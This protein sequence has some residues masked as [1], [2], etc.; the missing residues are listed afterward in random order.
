[1]SASGAQAGVGAP[2]VALS[3]R[4]WG[5]VLLIAALQF[6]NMLDFVIVM[7]IGPRLAQ[8]LDFP[9]SHLGWINGS[10]T[11]AASVMG[12]LGALF[13]ERFDRRKAVGVAVA[14]LVVGTALCGFANDFSSLLIAR[15]VAGAFGGPATSLCFAIIAD[16]IPN[17]ARG[18]AMG[19]VMGAFS[20]ASVFGVPSGLWM[21]EHFGWHAPF[22][23]VAA[24]GAVILVVSIFLL[25]SLT[26]HLGA[27]RN[28]MQ[29]I[30]VLL[31]NRNVLLS[32]AMTAVVMSAGFVLIPNIASYLQF[33]LGVPEAQVK[34]AYLVGGLASLVATQVGGRLVDRLGSFRVGTAGTALAA[35]V[36]YVFFYLPRES[37]PLGVVLLSF[38]MFM[39]AQGLRNV[40]YNT[41]TS[42]VPNPQHRATFQS[43]QSAVQHGATSLAAFGSGLLLTEV[44]RSPLASDLPGRPPRMLV[45]FD[46]VSLVSMSLSLMIP[47]L[48]LTVERRVVAPGLR[49]A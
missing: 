35:T 42:K 17:E 2:L 10:Y 12:L 38:A 4:Q 5:I 26:G 39:L 3:G 1:M 21:A 8:A 36:V 28:V 31:A 47:V 6:V 27:P 44:A 29:D 45:G 11:A 15:M 49:R 46:H 43:L 34:Y 24:L 18:R 16:T 23:T 14:G 13:L 32:F 48:L 22:F 7:P 40:S 41:L 37:M 20:L 30:G 9:S 25:P 33:N 19:T